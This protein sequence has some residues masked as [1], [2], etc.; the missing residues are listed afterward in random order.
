MT[1]VNKI[2]NKLILLIRPIENQWVSFFIDLQ[3]KVIIKYAK[4]GIIKLIG[5]SKNLDFSTRNKI[6]QNREELNNEKVCLKK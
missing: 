6:I 4:T 2:S 1:T 3:E 5:Q